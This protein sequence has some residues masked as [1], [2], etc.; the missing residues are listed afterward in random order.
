M[1]SAGYS[2]VTAGSAPVQTLTIDNNP[3]TVANET[4]AAGGDYTLLV[5]SNADGNQTTLISDNN[6]IPTTSSKL[7]LRILN[8]MSSLGDPINLTANFSPVAQGV[9]VG[10]AS[11]ATEIDAGTNYELDITDASNGTT[12]L[13]KTSVFS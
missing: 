8:G 6:Q 13:S 3:V 1:I 12:L 2:L 9:A 5:W 11:A 4:L 7:K 10:Q